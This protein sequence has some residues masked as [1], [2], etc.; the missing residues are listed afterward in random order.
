MYSRL[1]EEKREIR[2][3]KILPTEEETS[4]VS[5]VFTPVALLDNPLYNALS[6]TWG[7]PA[8][9]T[10]IYVNGQ[11]FHATKNLELALRV[12]R[13]KGM[14]ELLWVDAICIDQASV[15]DKNQQLP[16]M[17]DIY[18]KAKRTLVW[19]GDGEMS[20]DGEALAFSLIRRWVAAVKE[21]LDNIFQERVDIQ[22]HRGIYL[23]EIDAKDIPEG[24]MVEMWE[25]YRQKVGPPVASKLGNTFN[26]SEYAALEKL[27]HNPYWRRIWIMQE[28][29]LAQ[30]LVLLVGQDSI[31][32]DVFSRGHFIMTH[33]HNYGLAETLSKNQLRAIAEAQSE[34]LE[35]LI[36]FRSRCAGGEDISMWEFLNQN[37]FR[38]T[39]NP[40]DAVYGML[41]LVGTPEIPI[42]VDY[43][44][45]PVKLFVDLTTA[46]LS[47][48]LVG[49]NV[50]GLVGTPYHPEGPYTASIV[51]SLPSWVPHF[52][53]LA[54]LRPSPGYYYQT[55]SW[56]VNADTKI[57]STT[58]GVTGLVCCK[59][60]EVRTWRDSQYD[61]M[62]E[63][64]NLALSLPPTHPCGLPNIQAF[65]RTL[66]L[67]GTG[68]GFGRSGFRDE[69]Q[70]SSFFRR[71][72]G[73][74]ELFFI[75]VQN[76]MKPGGKL[77]DG[78][79]RG[80]LHQYMD[81]TEI[82]QLFNMQLHLYLQAFAVWLA[83]S[84]M[85]LRNFTRQAIF[86]QF[87]G[88]LE[89]SSRI[90]WPDIETPLNYSDFH[91]SFKICITRSNDREDTFF[92]TPDGYMGLGPQGMM[93]GDEIC[94]IPGCDSPLAIR[95]TP[96]TGQQ[97]VAMNEVEEY[98]LLGVCY[99]YGMMNGEMVVD[100]KNKEKLRRLVL[101]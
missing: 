51:L 15:E 8:I 100:P 28:F 42:R 13:K 48:P 10:P 27:F 6:Y 5:C 89:S 88:P 60:E 33:H 99:I 24:M 73:F 29:I 80:F 56:S 76:K 36:L 83:I 64:I 67:D 12:F 21:A 38:R 2:L 54:G 69:L 84:P 40:L 71:A 47:H 98:T 50:L 70:E 20:A 18:V 3:F 55:S 52:G 1:S 66:I 35:S 16:L 19:L 92:T 4:Q 49:P 85:K 39:S 93:V 62:E 53:R 30:D 75:L 43:A 74:M 79:A 63:W 65:F 78:G 59:V 86:D 44:M 11:I 91:N 41:G 31:N 61:T 57:T 77:C 72:A 101:V 58:L 22:I 97:H 94:C 96:R 37:H 25:L 82:D 26:K 9:T 45:S 23:S 17:R 7:D 46:F 14:E 34:P 87:C 32:L 95:R 81:D 90:P 68:F